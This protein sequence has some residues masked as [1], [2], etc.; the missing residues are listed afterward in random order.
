MNI[1][2]TDKNGFV[3]LR[4]FFKL[5]RDE[6]IK[7]EEIHEKGMKIINVLKKV[8]KENRLNV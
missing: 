8:I 2:D 6:K 5:F 4:E 1:I 3:S 7:N